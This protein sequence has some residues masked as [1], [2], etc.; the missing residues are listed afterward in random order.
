FS[1]PCK[2][3]SNDAPRFVRQPSPGLRQGSCWDV[4][5]LPDRIT[6][7]G[8]ITEQTSVGAYDGMADQ[9]RVAEVDF[10]PLLISAPRG[11]AHH[12]VLPTR[13]TQLFGNHGSLID[14]S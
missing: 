10:A 3:H 7:S 6:A 13:A 1:S 2:V 11:A 9:E 12:V 5:A 8:K 14:E 4:P